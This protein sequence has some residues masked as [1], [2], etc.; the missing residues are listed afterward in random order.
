MFG[1]FTGE[2]KKE[3]VKKSRE[4]FKEYAANLLEKEKSSASS[5]KTGEKCP[6]C[7][8]F[9]VIRRNS[10]DN[11]L[12]VGC[13]TFPKCNHTMNITSSEKN[14]RGTACLN[15]GVK[16]FYAEDFPALDGY[17]G[18]SDGDIGIVRA[19]ADKGE[20]KHLIYDGSGDGWVY[21]DHRDCGVLAEDIL[22][23]DDDEDW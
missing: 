5:G 22:S 2:N 14:N 21:H 18:I 1:I 17:T 23:N 12:F 7:S 10:F 16:V 4:S 3:D 13:S 11:S 9:L 6:K 15:N 20:I 8:G 19:Q